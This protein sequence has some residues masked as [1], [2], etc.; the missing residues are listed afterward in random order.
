MR[1]RKYRVWD[2]RL[3]KFTTEDEYRVEIYVDGSFLCDSFEDGTWE[4]T[5][6]YE[7]TEWTGL[8]D[9]EG[10]DIYEG[11][12]IKYCGF[13]VRNGKQIRPERQHVVDGSV[14]NLFRVKNTVSNGTV[15]VIGNRF[16]NPELLEEK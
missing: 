11:D 15:V 4:G 6:R 7:L 16:E 12:I 2:K 8:Q 5:E 1:E 9:S 3:K 10:K 14:E 13:E